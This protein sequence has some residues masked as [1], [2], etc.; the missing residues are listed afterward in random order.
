M[1]GIALAPIALRAL[2]PRPTVSI[3]ITS[4]N[5]A[6]FLAECLDS[7][8][9]QSVGAD[10]I[11]VIDDGSTDDTPR[12]LQGYM[13]RFPVIAGI[14]QA[15]GGMCAATNAAIQRCTG[16]VVLLLDADDVLAPR[17]VEKVLEALRKPIDGALPGWVHHPLMRFS[18]DRAYIGKAPRYPG[19]APH[20]SLAERVLHRAQSPV[21]TL[22]SGLA[23][24]REVLAAMGPLDSRRHMAQDLQLRTGAALLS[25]L[26]W[27]P[28]ALTRYRLHGEADSNDLM[29]NA[30]KVARS[31][32][33][34]VGVDAWVR[35]LLERRQAG[36][37]ASWPSL[38]EQP[39][40][41][42]LTFLDRWWSQGRRDH[43]LLRRLLAH[44]ALRDAP[45]R[46]RLYYRAGRLLPRPWFVACSRLIFGSTPLKSFLSHAL[47]RL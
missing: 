15:N 40:Y 2:P 30:D 3:A 42:W 23:F 10:Q 20:G 28:E 33:C 7:C 39:D 16:D 4:Y 41:L 21:V 22:N 1:S 26:A 25:P 35:Q 18:A 9:A 19:E 14:R 6:R 27:I 44:P 8:L 43:A 45:T 31:R 38:D 13:E 17:R 46:Q 47:G 5:Y 34:H 24:R 37:S 36:L 32:R 12:I 29:A 11:V